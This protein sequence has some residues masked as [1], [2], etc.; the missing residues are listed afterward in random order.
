MDVVKDDDER[1][2]AAELLEQLAHGPI[3]LTYPHRVAAVA[4]ERHERVADERA[5]AVLRITVVCQEL[6]HPAPR[7]D[8]GISLVQSDSVHHDGQDRPERDPL[9]VRETASL[10]DRGAP[11]EPREK[12]AGEARLPHASRTHH[13]DE[14][15]C[16]GVGD[17]LEGVFEPAELEVAANQRRVESA[18]PAWRVRGHVHQAPSRDGRGLPPEL[19]GTDRFGVHRVVNE[20]VSVASDE[21]L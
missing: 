4:E 12:L 3:R 7:L 18:A 11:T 19:Q 5:V 17:A 2:L 9:A 16:A 14:L 1:A 13:G 15:A 21:D 8:L 10:Q 6:P 20:P